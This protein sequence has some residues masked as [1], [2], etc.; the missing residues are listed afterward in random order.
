MLFLNYTFSD[1]N[2]PN[3]TFRSVSTAQNVLV[4]KSPTICTTFTYFGLEVEG[5]GFTGFTVCSFPYVFIG[6]PLFIP[7]YHP[8]QEEFDF[9]PCVN[10]DRVLLNVTGIILNLVHLLDWY[11][12]I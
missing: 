10:H 2:S 9:V 5:A 6:N 7:S 11:A 4:L 1:R 8:F 3:L 12:Y